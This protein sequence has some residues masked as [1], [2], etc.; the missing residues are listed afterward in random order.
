M[1]RIRINRRA[2]GGVFIVSAVPLGLLPLRCLHD[3]FPF[4]TQPYGAPTSRPFSSL[5]VPLFPASLAR[6]LPPKRSHRLA[7]P[8][9][10]RCYFIIYYFIPFLGKVCAGPSRGAG[11]GGRPSSGGVGG[12]P[13]T[14]ADPGRRTGES[15][16]GR[17]LLLPEPGTEWL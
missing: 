9:A 15:Q 14:A 6:A 8:P 2:L 13:A 11:R 17:A 7:R 4:P 16:A 3:G 12:R 5:H 1:T 10:G